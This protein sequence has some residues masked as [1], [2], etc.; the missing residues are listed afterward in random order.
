MA[1]VMSP[2]ETKDPVIET[3]R[4]LPRKTEA[5]EQQL[6]YAMH[7]LTFRLDAVGDGGFGDAPDYMNIVTSARTENVVSKE[8]S[9]WNEHSESRPSF[10]DT[11]LGGGPESVI[12][13][14]ILGPLAAPISAV[15]NVIGSIFDW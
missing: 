4:V 2:A 9:R 14:A 10:A 13:G 11:L 7:D 5:G 6:N 12:A 1:M 8:L 15:A 3:L